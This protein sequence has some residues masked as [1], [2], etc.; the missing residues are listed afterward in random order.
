MVSGSRR[1]V[2]PISLRRCF[3]AA[4]K[5]A[6]PVAH[7]PAMTRIAARRAITRPSSRPV[8][9]ACQQVG[10]TALQ[11][12]VGE[13]PTQIIGYPSWA[14]P[15]LL[16]GPV[17]DR[18]VV[19]LPVQAD[20][21]DGLAGELPA[22]DRVDELEARAIESEQEGLL[23]DVPPAHGL[24]HQVADHRQLSARCT[25]EKFGPD[26]G[27]GGR[28][29]AR[30]PVVVRSCRLEMIDFTDQA[31][32]A[33]ARIGFEQLPVQWSA[34]GVLQARAEETHPAFRAAIPSY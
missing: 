6:C 16:C 26:I 22:F 24:R 1:R 2:P 20:A 4:S 34:Q 11:R 33:A 7:S 31:R 3:R 29:A 30:D 15:L 32:E 10:V 12:Q 23:N 19:V 14:L 5:A 21:G 18:R 25:R 13:R 28:T 9:V 8:S 27:D 17:G